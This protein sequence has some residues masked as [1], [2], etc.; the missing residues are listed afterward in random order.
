MVMITLMYIAMSADDDDDDVWYAG[1]KKLM[2]IM[3]QI[4]SCL[5]SF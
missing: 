1:I 2:M 5:K 3:I 4:N